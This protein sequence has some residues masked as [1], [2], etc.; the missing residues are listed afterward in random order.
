[1]KRKD[2][3][4]TTIDFDEKLYQFINTVR[5]VFLTSPDKR[6]NSLS[7][8]QMVKILVVIALESNINPNDPRMETVRKMLAKEKIHIERSRLENLGRKIIRGL[9]H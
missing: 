6:I 1:M 2:S 3:K 5:G 8:S 7:F 4:K 9:D